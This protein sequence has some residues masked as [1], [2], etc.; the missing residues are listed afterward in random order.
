MTTHQGSASGCSSPFS[1]PRHSLSRASPVPQLAAESSTLTKECS[2]YFGQ[3]GQFCTITSSDVNAIERGSNVVYAS[4]VVGASLDSDLVLDGPGDN[5]ASGHVTLDL[6]TQTGIVTFSGG[7]GRFKGFHARVVV[8]FSK[9][10]NLWHWDG[11]YSF[12]PPGH[13]G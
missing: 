9:N 3:A 7:T 1:R 10:D 4:A 12:T 2:Q 8:T 13:D 11:T 5:N 6:A